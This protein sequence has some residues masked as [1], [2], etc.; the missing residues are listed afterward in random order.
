MSCASLAGKGADALK[1]KQARIG[2][3]PSARIEHGF[4]FGGKVKVKNGGRRLLSFDRTAV[5]KPD[6]FGRDY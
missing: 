5:W 2:R 3:A 6:R 1:Q 4:A